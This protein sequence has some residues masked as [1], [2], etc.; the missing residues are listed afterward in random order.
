MG[1]LQ[2]LRNMPRSVAQDVR[3]EEGVPLADK[4]LEIHDP[5]KGTRR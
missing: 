4:G 5:D 1:D 3:I 2:S